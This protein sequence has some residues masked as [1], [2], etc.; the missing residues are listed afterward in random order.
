MTNVV[1][2]TLHVLTHLIL[3][4]PPEVG[5]VIPILQLRNMRPRK[6]KLLGKV[7][8]GFRPDFLI[9]EFLFLSSRLCF[10]VIY[11]KMKDFLGFFGHAEWLAGS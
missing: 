8:P 9:P 1:P 4:N 5:T 6:I 2:N 11:F 3:N 10:C 7:E